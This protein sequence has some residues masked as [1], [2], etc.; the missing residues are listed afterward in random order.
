M[1][2]LTIQWRL[3]PTSLIIPPL[4]QQCKKILRGLVT[5][6]APP[7]LEEA[8]IE[9]PETIV[10][11]ESS[12]Y[13]QQWKDP[14]TNF[15]PQQ[16]LHFASIDISPSNDDDLT[17]ESMEHTLSTD[18]S[19]ISEPAYTILIARGP[20]QS[21]VAQYYLESLPLAGLVLVDP[22]I[23]PGN[24][25]DSDNDSSFRRWNE[26]TANLIKMLDDTEEAGAN[27]KNQHVFDN[28]KSK[29]AIKERNFIQD[30]SKKAHRPLYLEQSSVPILVMYS[31]H[32][33]CECNHKLCAEDTAEFHGIRSTLKIE[34]NKSGEQDLMVAM[35]EIHD[36]YE[37]FVA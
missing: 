36:W 26:S 28:L 11:I 10:L 7:P 5:S 1:A 31:G 23:L 14:F 22:L 2:S 35:S 4:K 30:L 34:R 3:P 9:R 29:S 37:E 20:I 15:C 6:S 17:I 16:G 19:S 18:I 33:D 21:L 24:G 8:L 27:A 25:R 13:K 12:L 32:H